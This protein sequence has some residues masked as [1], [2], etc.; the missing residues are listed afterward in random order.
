M[1]SELQ[2]WHFMIPLVGAAAVGISLYLFEKCKQRWPAI[3][4]AKQLS[5]AVSAAIGISVGELIFSEEGISLLEFIYILIIAA[6]IGLMFSLFERWAQKRPRLARWR[7]PLAFIIAMVAY[8][9][10]IIVSYYIPGLH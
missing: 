6:I 7:I 2:S 8:F 3:A 4:W 1:L 10:I 5:I 9:I